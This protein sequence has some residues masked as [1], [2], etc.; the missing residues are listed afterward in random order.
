MEATTAGVE[1]VLVD[2]FNFK[3]KPSAT[4][5]TERRNCTF[6]VKDLIFTLLVEFVF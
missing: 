2:S 5:V 4:Y 6:S 3:L 1:D